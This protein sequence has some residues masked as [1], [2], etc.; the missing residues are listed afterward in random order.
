[1]P[2]GAFR[3]AIPPA[4]GAYRLRAALE[5][6]A[7]RPEAEQELLVL[8]DLP[9]PRGA[10]LQVLGERLR[11]LLPDAAAWA[12]SDAP[13][14][15]QAGALRGRDLARAADWARGGGHLA[16]LDVDPEQAER[17]AGALG[18]PLQAHG[19]RGS[20]LGYF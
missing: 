17:L 16:L 12:G 18:L 6:G 20:F 4:P 7:E 15:A 8:P 11:R 19:T 9:A 14:L 10:G 5:L 3:A 13:L 1:A 2:L